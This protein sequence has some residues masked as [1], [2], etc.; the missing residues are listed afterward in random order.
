[1]ISAENY[2]SFCSLHK[3]DLNFNSFDEKITY[4]QTNISLE[5]YKSKYNSDGWLSRKIIAI[6]MAIISGVIKTAY[7][8][9]LKII[10]SLSA[11]KYSSSFYKTFS[12]DKK[13]SLNFA[14]YRDLKESFGWLKTIFNDASGQFTV[15]ESWKNKEIYQE[16][17]KQKQ[18]EATLLQEANQALT[19]DKPA[20]AEAKINQIKF[21]LEA[22]ND[23][24]DKT[25]DI[26]LKNEY[27]ASAFKL[28]SDQYNNITG[29][30]SKDDVARKTIITKIAILL[31]PHLKNDD[32]TLNTT[33]GLIDKLRDDND[34]YMY[35]CG[36]LDKLVES[37]KIPGIILDKLMPIYEE[38][39]KKEN[40]AKETKDG[41][42]KNIFRITSCYIT[43]STDEATLSKAFK[44]INKLFDNSTKFDYLK[45]ILN[46]FIKTDESN[47]G[48]ILDNLVPLYDLVDNCN[49]LSN[50]LKDETLDFIIRKTTFEF[51]ESTGEEVLAKL[52]KCV[53]MLKFQSG[54]AN[55]INSIVERSTENLDLKSIL[56]KLLSI[57]AITK[58][59]SVKISDEQLLSI[60]RTKVLNKITNLTDHETLNKASE[61]I[62]KLQD[63]NK[64]KEFYMAIANKS[65]EGNNLNND[66][67]KANAI[68]SKIENREI[69]AQVL[70]SIFLDN[71]T[72]DQILNNTNDQKFLTASNFIKN[73]FSGNE[74]LFN[75]FI[76]NFSKHIQ[77]FSSNVQVDFFQIFIKEFNF[78]LP[79]TE[80]VLKSLESLYRSASN[81]DQKL[82]I[83]RLI[84]LIQ[85][86]EL[87]NEISYDDGYS[88]YKNIIEFE[89][90][91]YTFSVNDGVT[92]KI[93]IQHLYNKCLSDSQF[94]KNIPLCILNKCKD[95]N[96]VAQL[97]G[98][99][100]VHTNE[101][102]DFKIHD[103]WNP[104]FN[105]FELEKPLNRNTITN[106]YRKLSL[107]YHPDKNKGPNAE[108][109]MKA[110]NEIRDA[111]LKAFDE[112]TFDAKAPK[113]E[114]LNLL[115]NS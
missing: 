30:T 106:S 38:I 52:L 27:Y 7:H 67:R 79:R 12:D 112:R 32:E 109:Q 45:E 83:F 61:L 71:K 91:E 39:E 82:K 28:Y 23:L 35:Y 50:K 6:P 58:E 78:N 43:N 98:I 53:E 55:W 97:A 103:S 14:I 2:K 115:S 37:E 36:L 20:E 48:T 89:D 90:S 44:L 49:F 84:A 100:L 69:K 33:F 3:K 24:I 18:N 9:G 99:N 29:N 51:N 77:R 85:I 26:Y 88:L 59:F 74:E 34:K 92:F 62:G 21:N 102:N 87:D 63:V 19:K 5:Q 57:F 101:K 65:I 114:N 113:I 96:L 46:K 68:L 111:L 107:R 10:S 17:I 47:P 95:K 80:V 22:K 108:N 16:I 81:E 105:L 73:F 72:L 60:L 41:I 54:K 110:L 4:N 15:F 56:G 76:S 94:F 104:L 42:I 11:E 93:F 1:M 70:E 64:K 25:I 66:F 40:V 8:V 31:I 13:T 86:Q 75:G